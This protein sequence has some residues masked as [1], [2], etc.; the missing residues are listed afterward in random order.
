MLLYGGGEHRY[1]AATRSRDGATMH[2]ALWVTRNSGGGP[3]KGRAMVQLDVV[4]SGMMDARMT[5]VDADAMRR[6]L[7]DDGRVAL[8]G[9]E[10]DVDRD[11][12]RPEADAQ[13]AQVAA[14]LR[15]DARLS[16][17]V[18]GHTDDRGGR[19]HNLALSRRRAQRV[20][21]ALATRH[22][23]ARTRMEAVGRGASAPL[24]P[25]DS[26]DGRARNRRVEIVRR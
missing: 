22:G 26:E 12:L 16:V 3:A 4:E 7:A 18:E 17:R 20:V 11:T 1:L 24:A 6:D 2:V 19:D 25:N 21:D 15:Q 8:Y 5:V 23:I 9:I 10:F 14:L 13:I